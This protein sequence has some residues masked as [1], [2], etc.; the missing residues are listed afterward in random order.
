MRYF[1]IYDTRNLQIRRDQI[2]AVDNI[3]VETAALDQINMDSESY[4]LLY[5]DSAGFGFFSLCFFL[6]NFTFPPPFPVL[7]QV[8]FLKSN[9]KQKILE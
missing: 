5:K 7:F 4:C 3:E 1:K 6:N 9:R 8:N 2:V